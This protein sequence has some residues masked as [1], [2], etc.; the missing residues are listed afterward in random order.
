MP[1]HRHGRKVGICG[2]GPSDNPE[3]AAFLVEA[4]I[5]FHVPQ[6]GQRSAGKAPGGRKRKEKSSAAIQKYYNVGWVE[7]PRNPTFRECVMLQN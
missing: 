1:A 4:G 3:F 6:P 7:R 5:G 2:Q